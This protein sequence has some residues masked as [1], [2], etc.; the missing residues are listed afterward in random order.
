M[1]RW[2]YADLD[3]VVLGKS[4]KRSSPGI[5]GFSY[6]ALI[7]IYPA[8]KDLLLKYV[9]SI[10][11]KDSLCTHLRARKIVFIQKP[12]KD[13]CS[14][15]GYRPIVLLEILYK[16]YSSLI[17]NRLKSVMSMV[18]TSH[19]NAYQPGK[20]CAVAA[21]C[22][23]DSKNLMRKSGIDSA[24]L[25]LDFSSAFD[26]MSLDYT[27]ASLRFFGVPESLIRSICVLMKNPIARLSVNGKMTDPFD[28]SRR[29]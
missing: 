17:A 4:H 8:I 12:G 27:Y 6:T 5:S 23:M 11:D 9:N 7:M 15:S 16:I 29:G 19:Q 28:Q 24:L 25:S 20:S 22:I 10:K 21:L 2:S 1:T 3:K 26:M 18:M 14:V 13:E